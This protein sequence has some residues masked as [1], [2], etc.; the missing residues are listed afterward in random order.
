M[1]SE[2][3]DNELGK[4]NALVE[5]GEKLYPDTAKSGRENIR[6]QLRIARDVWDSLLGELNDAQIEVPR[7][8]IISV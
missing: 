2:E 4:L 7:M 6:Q 1:L 5:S 3:K 8:S